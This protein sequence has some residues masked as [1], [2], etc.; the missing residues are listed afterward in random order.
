[1]ASSQTIEEPN[2][3]FKIELFIEDIDNGDL[4][5]LKTSINNINNNNNHS[6]KKKDIPL[7]IY[8][9]GFLTPNRLSFIIENC[10]DILCISSSLLKI[11]IK[12]NEIQLL[13]II[14]GNF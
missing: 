10:S 2:N 4:E 6:K 5:I 9:N 7:E 8:K 11:L 1:M 12:N 3:N 13:N 14:F